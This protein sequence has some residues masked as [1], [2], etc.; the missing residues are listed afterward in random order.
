MPIL[1]SLAE[2]DGHRWGVDGTLTAADVFIDPQHGGAPDPDEREWRTVAVA[3]MRRGGRA[4]FALDLT[5]PEPLVREV[6]HPSRP[7]VPPVE[8]V[9]ANGVPGSDPDAAPVPACHDAIGADDDGETCDPRLR[10]PQPLWE[11]TDEAD[12]DGN[13]APDLGQTWS[14][15]NLGAV[16]IWRDLD[17]DGRRS[18]DEVE[19]RFVAVFGGGFDPGGAISTR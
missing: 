2:T 17:G 10:Y 5:Q 15:P 4:Y 18:D 11:F 19:P 13:G 1:T 14:T 9:P 3:G 7:E 6:R 12:E 8:Y 16:E